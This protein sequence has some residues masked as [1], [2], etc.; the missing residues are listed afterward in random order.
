MVDSWLTT[1]PETQHVRRDIAANSS[2]S[3]AEVY[4][5]EF[6]ACNVYAGTWTMAGVDIGP[7]SVNQAVTAVVLAN[8]FVYFTYFEN[9]GSRNAPSFAIRG[10]LT[11]TTQITF[12]REESGGTVDGRWWVVESTDGSFTVDKSNVIIADASSSDDDTGVSVTAANTLMLGSYKAA[13]TSEFTFANDDMNAKAEL[14]GAG[15]L[16]IR[17]FSLHAQQLFL[18]EL[19][20]QRGNETARGAAGAGSNVLDLAVLD[21]E[22]DPLEREREFNLETDAADQDFLDHHVHPWAV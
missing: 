21:P 8:S 3:Y 19:G 20:R 2:E 5:I 11:T 17:E 4:L 14:N 22:H 9:A 18:A 16:K 6:D 13:G 7:Q 10:E 15:E 12:D 1:S